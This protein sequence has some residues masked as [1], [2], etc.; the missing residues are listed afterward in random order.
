LGIFKKKIK[1]FNER[2]KVVKEKKK[3]NNTKKLP[4]NPG[5]SEILMQRKF[6]YWENIF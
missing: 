4:Q 6:V 1:I 2:Y 5:G 3:A